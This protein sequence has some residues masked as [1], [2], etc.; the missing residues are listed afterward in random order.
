VVLITGAGSGM[1]RAMAVAFAALGRRVVAVDIDATS[2]AAT[3]DQLGGSGSS[4]AAVTADVADPHDV[5]RMIA[6]ATSAFGRIDVV[7]NNAGVLDAMRSALD[8]TDEQWAR[9]L[10]VNLTSVFL[11][12]R[13]AIPVMLEHGGGVIVNTAS[14]AGLVSGAGGAAYTAS[15]HGVVGLTRQ[16]AFDHGPDGIRVNAIC[17]G[18]VDTAMTRGLEMPPNFVAPPRRLRMAARRMAQP[19]EIAKLAVYLASDEASFIHGSTFT[20]DGGWTMQ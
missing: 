14:I 20:I 10:A 5:A 13:A 18:A 12:S 1:G 11:V 19:E 2:A 7:C 15:K 4:A 16:L 6:A 9:V 17:P 8:T 3:V